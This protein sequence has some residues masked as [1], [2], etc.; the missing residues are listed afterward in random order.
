MP[1]TP[2]LLQIISCSSISSVEAMAEQLAQSGQPACCVLLSP[3]V[4][5]QDEVPKAL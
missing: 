4:L 5:E 2:R 1:C 3:A